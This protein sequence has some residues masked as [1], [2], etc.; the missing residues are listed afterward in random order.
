MKTLL[1]PV[2]FSPVADNALRYAIDMARV[3][4]A[5]IVL[6]N[7]YQVPV[8]YTD[9]PVSMLSIDEIRHSSEE[10][11][12][13]LEHDIRHETSGHLA[14][15]TI[16]KMGDTVDVLEELC[17]S[18]EPFAVVMGSHGLTG[19]ERLIMGSTTLTAMRHLKYPVIVVPPGTSFKA[20]RK[21]GLACDFK[22]VDSIPVDYIKMI[23]REFGAELHVLNVE[24]KNKHDHDKIMQGA[25]VLKNLLN[26]VNPVYDF[27]QHDHVVE[28]IN[29]FADSNNLDV[30]MVMPRKHKFLDSLFSKSKSKELVSHA[31]IP[32]VSIHE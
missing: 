29:E 24:S 11:L 27:L 32:I 12:G 19:F 30:L 9:V 23:V 26:D 18:I 25:S 14:V 17:E 28:G 1:V 4:D 2:D 10:K 31:H 22:D 21:I 8:T 6:V 15:R 5:S 13:K 20:I 7:I 16:S 3:I